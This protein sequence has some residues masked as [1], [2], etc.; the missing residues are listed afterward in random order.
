MTPETARRV[1]L[2]TR[3]LADTIMTAA[4]CAEEI[5]AAVLADLDGDGGHPAQAAAVH[6]SPAQSDHQQRPV[7][8]ESTL[9][10]IWRG[11]SLH[12]GHTLAFRLLDRLARRPN[13]YVTHLD[14]LQDVWD[15]DAR[16]ITTI[17][18]TVRH[19]QSKLRAGGMPELAAAIR[20]HNGRYILR[21]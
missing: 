10:V 3:Q 19:L 8:D 2:L 6:L 11:T 17:R 21:L 7:L 13:Q 4:L 15:G 12:L 18:S 5:R 9:C 14:L 1:V 16:E 20:G